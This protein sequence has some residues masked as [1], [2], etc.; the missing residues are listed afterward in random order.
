MNSCVFADPLPMSEFDHVTRK[1]L[2]DNAY[3]RKTMPKDFVGRK[4]ADDV[5]GLIETTLDGVDVEQES[6][7]SASVLTMRV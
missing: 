6:K 2:Y 1:S 7:V 3:N 4:D 5:L